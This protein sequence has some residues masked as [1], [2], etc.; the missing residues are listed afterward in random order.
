[1]PD[2]ITRLRQAIAAL[3]AQRATLGEDIVALAVAPLRERLARLQDQPPAQQLRQVSVLF[4]D[5]VGSTSLSQHLGPEDISAVMD[6]ALASFARIVEAQ[7][8]IALQYAGDSMLAVFGTPLARED[9]AQRAV[10]AAL[11]ILAAAR[12]QSA[13][14]QQRHG[15]EGFGVRAGIA[16]GGVLL[17]GGIDGEHSIRGMTVNLAAR[18]E[19]TAP[20]G[21]LRICPDTRRLVRG[22]FAMTEQA[23]LQV[24]GRDEAI[25]TWLVS[26]ATSSAALQATRGVAGLATPLVGREAPWRALQDAYHA[27]CASTRPGL[28]LLMVLGDAG[29]GKSRLTAEFRTWTLAQSGGAQWLDAQA[30][31]AGQGRPYGLLRQLFTRRLQVLDSDTAGNA[32]DKWLQAMATLLHSPGDAAVLG[33]LLGLDFSSHAELGPLLG[34]GKQLRDRAFFHASQALRHIAAHGPP[35]LAWLDDLHWA[36]A[37]TLEFI[38]YLRAECAA[39]P[40]LLLATARPVFD[41]LHTGWIAAACQLRIDLPPLDEAAGAALANLLLARLDSIPRSLREHLTLGAAGNPFFM[42]E[43]VNMLIDRGVIVP[44]GDCDGG[45]PTLRPGPAPW[46][47]HLERLGTAALPVTLTGVLQARLDALPADEA[48]V[49]QLAAIVGTVFWDDALHALGSP[50]PLPLS[51]LLRR[52]LIV[53]HATSSLEGRHEFA[54]RHHLLHQVC[55]QRV[56][57][58]VKQAAH[59]RAA[60]WLETLPGQRHCALIAEHHEQGGQLQ[61]A[62]D[63]WQQAAEQAQARYAN[64]QALAHAARALQL[65]A[66]HDGA[67]RFELC[68]LRARVLALVGEPALLQ[69]ELDALDQLSE[70]LNDDALRSQA[71]ERRACYLQESSDAESVLH[72]AERAL[73]LAPAHAPHLKVWAGKV[74][75]AALHLLGQHTQAQQRAEQT[76]ALA[77]QIGERRVEGVLLN[78]LGVLASDRGDIASSMAWYTQALACHHETGNRGHEA[79]VLSNL[80]Y[81]QLGMGAYSA[82][83]ERFVAARAL[84]VQIGQ[85]EKEGVVLINLA[86]V[87]LN[88]GQPEQAIARVHEALPLLTASGSRWAAAAALRVL[89]QAE[90]ALGRPQAAGDHLAQALASFTELHMPHLAL[91]VRASLAQAAL[92]VGDRAAALA[93]A[94]AVSEHLNGGAE[95]DG[96]EEPLR[97]CLDCWQVLDALGDASAAATLASAQTLLRKRAE[98]IADPQRRESF[99]QQ[100]PYH[101]RLLQAGA[102]R[103][104]TA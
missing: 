61:L 9:D 89:G 26:G 66:P 28:S 45:M 69:T 88:T 55:S 10:H 100:V 46:R 27:W 81:A 63:A 103:D 101:R 102:R 52:Q 98:R 80:G 7:G 1:M 31:E 99:L 92:A 23:P 3:D 54:F 19:Q 29:L 38:D 93:Q 49:L 4:T 16:T 44:D 59:A 39:L 33:H 104:A 91:E 41:E 21:A 87:A 53:E 40:L 75:V 51:N 90:L 12:E 86:L 96:T 20:P 97:L 2:D 78:A 70:A 17:G 74:V 79:G 94:L 43:L 77:R 48:Q 56:L 32:R 60:Q 22:L 84:F 67:R 64:A 58:R 42:E 14:V 76:L 65:T 71:A 24:K 13:A 11:S 34:E 57:Q 8:G 15:F 35:L 25:A 50:R 82:A 95:F 83:S 85:R 37:G 73:R 62:R 47:L 68:L 5:V 36:D 72:M 30:H 6:G 18:M